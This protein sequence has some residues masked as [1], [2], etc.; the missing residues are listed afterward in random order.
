M[1]PRLVRVRRRARERG[2]QV[3][4]A[5]QPTRSSRDDLMQ[6]VVGGEPFERAPDLRVVE[7]AR[8]ERRR[9]LDLQHGDAGKAE[10]AERGQR[11]L[12]LDRCVRGVE[13]DAEVSAD[14][15][16][17]AGRVEPRERGHAR[18]RAARVEMA[19]EELYRF[20]DRL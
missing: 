12:E 20:A 4:E 9:R 8:A 3:D 13:T 18:D 10:G 14:R 6:T 1:D 15:V 17:G 16:G 11:L 2:G 7:I 19:I 5:L